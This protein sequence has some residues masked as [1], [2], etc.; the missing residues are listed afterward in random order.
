MNFIYSYG[1]TALPRSSSRCLSKLAFKRVRKATGAF[2]RLGKLVSPRR[3]EEL[4]QEFISRGLFDYNGQT[5]QVGPPRLVG[6]PS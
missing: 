6:H 2:R 5:T 1:S 4:E 3:R